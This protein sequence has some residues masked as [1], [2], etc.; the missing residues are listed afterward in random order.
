M[1][2]LDIEGLRVETPNDIMNFITEW[3]RMLQFN[4]IAHRGSLLHEWG[5][6]L[7][8]L[9]RRKIFITVVPYDTY[10]WEMGKK[11]KEGRAA[12]MY[13][14]EG[15]PFRRVYFV[16][17][18]G[19]ELW[20][21]TINY[22]V[23]GVGVRVTYGAENIRLDLDVSE[24]PSPGFLDYYRNR[25]DIINMATSREIH[26]MVYPDANYETKKLFTRILKLKENECSG[27]NFVSAPTPFS[28]SEPTT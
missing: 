16:P 18:P 7:A 22:I 2:Y 4:Y 24:E 9:G 17:F 1:L 3:A 23:D 13:V 8:E 15:S 19:D 27:H 20:D 11:G 12:W 14:D 28:K 25:E 5:Y 10:F 6:F 21:S 26:T